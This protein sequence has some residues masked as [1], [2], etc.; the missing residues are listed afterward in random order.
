MFFFVTIYA[1]KRTWAFWRRVQYG[2]G[3][4]TF[5][6]LLGG[7]FYVSYFYAPASCFDGVKNGSE[8]G[9]DC[10]GSC[11][12]ICSFQVTPPQVS[13]AQSFE[14]TE[15]VYNAVAYVEN[16]NQAAASPEVPY[17]FRLF[18]K[19][20][21]IVERTGS[22]ILPADSVYPIFAA[23]IDTSGRVPT[24][25]ILELG[26]AEKWL[27]AVSGR[28]QF[29]VQERTLQNVDSRPRLEAKIYNNALTEAEDIEVVATIFDAQGNALTSSRTFINTFAPRS[30]EIVV[31]TWPQPIAKTIRSCEI[32]TDV[33][34]AIDLSGSM[35]ND[36]GTPP[37]PISSVLE[38]AQAFTGRLQQEDQ[39]SVV[40]FA[41]KAVL[42]APLSRAFSAIAT[43]IKTLAISPEEEQGSTNTGDAIKVATS[44]LV[45]SRH[46]TEARKVLVLLTDG[47]ATAPGED[48][49]TYALAAASESKDKDVIIYTIGLGNEV[50]MDFVRSLASDSGKA[51]A[52]L[53]T[54]DVNNIYRSITASLCED[55]PAVIEIIPKTTT[56][57]TTD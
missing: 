5:L 11:S 41:T 6:F 1:M 31:F 37:Q 46:N 20:G 47:L 13:W 50:N 30:E 14:V 34:L 45:S 9:V 19:D 29:T 8:Q 32:P 2:T 3:F 25:T 36:G 44:E 52:A 23:R 22:T 35:N 57:F 40:T 15:G 53:T 24:Q 26:E 55:G 39:V 43:Q 10:G 4:L 21:L 48:P 18:D 42:V 54:N 56:G 17:T 27:P 49:D 7:V 12:R 28:E 51:Y 38:A 16:R 33:A